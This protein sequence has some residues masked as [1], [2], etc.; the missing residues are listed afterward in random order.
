MRKA[1]NVRVAGSMRMYPRTGNRPAHDRRQ[2]AC[3]IDRRLAP[4]GDERAGNAAR[5]TLFAVRVNRVGQL[6]LGAAGDEIGGGL[7]RAAIHAHVERLVALKAESPAG[8][9]ELHRRHAEIG[10][11]AV[12]ER[13]AA[14]IEDVFNR[15]IVG[16]HQI[17]A[18]GERRERGAR[19]R[20]ARLRRDRDR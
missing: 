14:L 3:R 5:E 11:R 6:L 17:H 19:L 1:W 9:V 18:I 12:D 20:S 16:V 2:P 10:E 8:C 4:R 7:S 15:S 13:D